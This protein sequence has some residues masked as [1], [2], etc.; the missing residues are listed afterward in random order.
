MTKKR[1]V[2][3]LIVGSGRVATHLKHYLNLK[4]IPFLDWNRKEHT[5]AELTSMLPDVSNVFLLLKDSAIEEF[6]DQYL[7]SF[8][9]TVFHFSGSLNAEGIE[10][11]HPLMTFGPDLY[12]LSFYEQIHFAS[13][14]KE[15]FKACF[16]TLKNPVFELKDEDKA[17][18][19]ALCVM[20][21]NFP[22]V[23][24]QACLSRFR[25]LGVPPA[26]VTLYLQKNLENFSKNPYQSL[27]GPLA[28]KDWGTIEKNV[29]A[30]PEV[31]KPLYKAFV[32]F[33]LPEPK[34]EKL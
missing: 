12:S 21:G 20:S 31:L 26:A 7:S 30:L 32:K 4:K 11:F 6:R 18:Y 15:K 29:Q 33:Y 13:S 34:S 22:Q 17:Y 10:S 25:D 8:E 23:L 14:S 9:G 28:R 1:S 2:D 27:T 19:H 5:V 16:P 3:H 24:W